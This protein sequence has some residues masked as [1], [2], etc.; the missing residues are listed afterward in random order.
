MKPVKGLPPTDTNLKNS[1]DIS[2]EAET[3]F[4]KLCMTKH[5]FPSAMVEKRPF[6]TLHG[7]WHEIAGMW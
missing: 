3:N 2:L 4:S 7:K 1:H 5:I 6:C